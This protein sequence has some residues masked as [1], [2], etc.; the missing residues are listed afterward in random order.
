MAK[1][2]SIADT[3]AEIGALNEFTIQDAIALMPIEDIIKREMLV[4]RGLYDFATDVE[5]AKYWRERSLGIKTDPSEDPLRFH[6]PAET[7]AE[8]PAA[9]IPI[10]ERSG[11]VDIEVDG[12]KLNVV[13]SDGTRK[14][15]T[16][17]GAKVVDRI[18]SGNSVSRKPIRM[19]I[20]EDCYEYRVNI[21]KDTP[22]SVSLFD[23]EG[24]LCH[25]QVK[26][27]G[28]F[29]LLRSNVNLN[30]HVVVVGV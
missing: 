13:M 30:G 22:V 24:G 29:L 17:P 4:E 14:A 16:L 15:I 21:G 25:A 26:W 5:L 23:P 7:P 19:F 3:A 28:A 9:N 8:T 10:P 11:I 2:K 1:R 12:G 27:V 18:V 20:Q 6:R